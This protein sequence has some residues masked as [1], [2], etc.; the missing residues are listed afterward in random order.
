VLVIVVII[1]VVN[2]LSEIHHVFRPY[3][4]I[5]LNVAYLLIKVWQQYA[6]AMNAVLSEQPIRI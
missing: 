5:V 3:S 4:T 6:I 2:I 1:V